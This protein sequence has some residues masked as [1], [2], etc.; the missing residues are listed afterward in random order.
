[1]AGLD[2]ATQACLRADAQGLGPPVTP[3]DEGA[4]V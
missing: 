2:P 1:M 4:R 3:G